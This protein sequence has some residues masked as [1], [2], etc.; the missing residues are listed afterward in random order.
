MNLDGY[1]MPQEMPFAPGDNIDMHHHYDVYICKMMIWICVGHHFG[2]Q[3]H[4]S[5][6]HFLEDRFTEDHFG[7]Q[8]RFLEGLSMEDLDLAHLFPL[9]GNEN[10]KCK[11]REHLKFLG[12]SFLFS[13]SKWIFD[14]L[15]I[16]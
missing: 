2:D 5:E 16:Q 14:L 4:F 8:D 12:C 15:G 7:G 3:D 6:D 11:Q 13:K 10:N 9:T 1:H